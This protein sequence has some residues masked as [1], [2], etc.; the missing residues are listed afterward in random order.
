[1]SSVHIKTVRVHPGDTL[2]KI[3]ERELGAGKYWL[4]LYLMNAVELATGGHKIDAAHI[5]PN[6]IYPGSKITVVD[7]TGFEPSGN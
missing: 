1:M 3:A 7:F 2:W 5:G 4:N 6:W